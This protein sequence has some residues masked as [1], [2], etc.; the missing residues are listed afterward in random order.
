MTEAMS[1]LNDRSWPP[2][3][4]P[5]SL[6]AGVEV[7]ADQLPAHLAEGVGAINHALKSTFSDGVLL[8]S[9]VVSVGGI[10]NPVLPSLHHTTL[11]VDDS[12]QS[13]CWPECATCEEVT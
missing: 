5:Q 12:Q 11:V 3:F 13:A 2:T 7:R 6:E 4:E 10:P 1:D 9:M 8:P